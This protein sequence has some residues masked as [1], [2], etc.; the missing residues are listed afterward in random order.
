MTESRWVMVNNE[1]DI[2]NARLYTRQMA[3]EAGLQIMDQARISLAVSSLA[4]IIRL[5]AS[6]PGQIV[7]YRINQNGRS[8]IQVS[9]IVNLNSEAEEVVRSLDTS[10]LSAM[11][12]E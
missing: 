8:G 2:I 1:A 10:A 11:V 12:D 4:Y 9:W 5:V 7:I 3:K 6:H